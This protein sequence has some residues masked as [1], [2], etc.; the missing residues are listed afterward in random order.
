ME[1]IKCSKCGK[2]IKDTDNRCPYCG[3][4][5]NKKRN[6]S[7]DSNENE[8]IKYPFATTKLVIGITSI[9]I[10]TIM[11]V[12]SHDYVVTNT[13]L[14]YDDE[15]IF[16]YIIVAILVFFAGIMSIA[17][18]NKKESGLS[19][20]PIFLYCFSLFPASQLFY[21]SSLA[22]PFMGLTVSFAVVHFVSIVMTVGPTMND[23]F[24]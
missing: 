24:K 16:C 13:D 11:L 7:S 3:S 10:S 8:R 12:L 9:L 22:I 15:L 1:I 5:N 18:R 21:I 23:W 2:Y 6:E 17:T 20:I 4:I 14:F 19:F